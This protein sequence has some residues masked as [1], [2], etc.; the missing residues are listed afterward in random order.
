[1]EAECATLLELGLV[2]GIVTDDSDVFLFGATRVY[3]N[4]FSQGKELETFLASD[5]ERELALSR[6][7]LIDLACLLGSDYTDGVRGIGPITAMEILSEFA[8]DGGLAGFHAW[9]GK[10]LF[11]PTTAPP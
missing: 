3:K 11:H 9:W 5:L 8:Q 4:F 7:R 1:A 10:Q 2:D 6:E